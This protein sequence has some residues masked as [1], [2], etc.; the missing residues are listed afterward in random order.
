MRGCIAIVHCRQMRELMSEKNKQDP[1]QGSGKA[2]RPSERM[3]RR[4]RAAEMRRRQASKKE[5]RFMRMIFGISGFALLLT[6]LF[7]FM[8]AGE[9]FAAEAVVEAN[10]DNAVKSTSAEATS[11]PLVG[12]FTLIDI[13]GIAFVLVSGYVVLRRFKNKG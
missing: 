8:Y 3:F 2:E 4:S 13:A 10:V 5:D 9:V 11:T 1:D 6:F 12:K 7:F